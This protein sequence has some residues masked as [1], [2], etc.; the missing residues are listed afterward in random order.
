MGSEALAARVLGHFRLEWDDTTSD[1]RVTVSPV[2]CLGL[3]SV[4]PAA[5][6]GEAIHA[7]LSAEALIRLAEGK[8]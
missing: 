5:Q 2:F 3:C 6:V 1:G 4:A 8:E 7:R